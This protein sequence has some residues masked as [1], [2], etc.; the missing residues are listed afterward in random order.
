MSVAAG[1]AAAG[2]GAETGTEGR[3]RLVAVGLF[4]MCLSVGAGCEQD[5][6][7]GAAAAGETAGTLCALTHCQTLCV[8]CV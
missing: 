1:G 4:V 5:E 3:S 6:Q 8:L 2:E 7:R